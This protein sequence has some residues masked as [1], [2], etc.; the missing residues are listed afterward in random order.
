MA[1]YTS[2]PAGWTEQIVR[3]GGKVLA[4]SEPYREVQ[5]GLLALYRKTGE[6]VEMEDYLGDLV[7]RARQFH[8]H[9]DVIAAIGSLVGRVRDL[10][11]GRCDGK[12][13]LAGATAT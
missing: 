9:E 8:E 3:G 1:A 13:Q 7:R 10:C 2:A 5:D 12:V 6:E 4:D 11:G